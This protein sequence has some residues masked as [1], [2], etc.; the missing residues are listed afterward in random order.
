MQNSNVKQGRL[1]FVLGALASATLAVGGLSGCSSKTKRASVKETTKEIRL[2]E[3]RQRLESLRKNIPEETKTYNDEASFILNLFADDSKSPYQISS[4]FNELANRKREEYSKVERRKREDF[5]RDEKKKREGV[6]DELKKTRE[7]QNLAKMSQADR[8]R[9]FSEQ[10]SE[11]RK[12]FADESETRRDFESQLRQERQDFEAQMRDVRSRFD[13]EQRTYTKT[14]N[15]RKKMDS[16]KDRLKEKAAAKS[17]TLS[18][19]AVPPGF[20]EEDMKDLESIP[21]SGKP[22]EPAGSQ[23]QDQ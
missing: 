5:S 19:R 13:S 22:I 12:F 15:E 1:S 11:R 16:E 3:D 23:P 6:L 17:T 20:T 14:Y 8:N 18:G 21:K 4:K 7:S 10:D 9:F 2:T